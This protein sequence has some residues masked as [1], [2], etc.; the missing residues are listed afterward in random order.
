VLFG[1]QLILPVDQIDQVIEFLQEAKT[2]L[3]ECKEQ[4]SDKIYKEINEAL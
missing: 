3:E 1:V 4:V 2:D